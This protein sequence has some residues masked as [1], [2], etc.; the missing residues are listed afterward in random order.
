MQIPSVLPSPGSAL[1]VVGG[2]AQGSMARTTCCPGGRRPQEARMIR[3]HPRPRLLPVCRSAPG[4]QVVRAIE[5][6]PWRENESWSSS[7]LNPSFPSST[8]SHPAGHRAPLALVPVG[9]IESSP[10]L[11]CRVGDGKA[12]RP[13]G[14]LEGRYSM[15]L[16]IWKGSSCEATTGLQERT[17]K[18]L[19]A[20][21]RDAP[22]GEPVPGTEVP[23]YSQSSL[24]G[25]RQGHQKHGVLWDSRKSLNSIGPKSSF[26]SFERTS[27]FRSH[28]MVVSCTWERLLSAKLNFV[29]FLCALRTRT[30]SCP[31]HQALSLRSAKQA[32]TGEIT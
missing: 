27:G 12:A 26:H 11:Q 20:S 23:G 14:T 29:S 30:T 2:D 1:R 24:P 9:T 8:Y 25:R 6:S 4:Q 10:A 5:L 16:R 21:L 15:P 31:G 3:N 32:T 22:K 28:G 7:L 18:A 13:G 17:C 19:Q